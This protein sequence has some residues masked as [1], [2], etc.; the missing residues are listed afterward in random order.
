MNGRIRKC[1]NTLAYILLILF[2]IVCVF[3]PFDP[4]GLK[5]PLLLLLFVLNID[6]FCKAFYKSKWITTFLLGFLFPV[7]LCIYSYLLTFNSYV[8]LSGTYCGLLLLLNIVIF[9]DK[10]DYDL[11]FERSVIILAFFIL[12]LFLADIFGIYDINSSPIRDFIYTYE[13]GFVGKS[14]AYS[15]YYKI[16]LRTSPLIIY[17]YAK[18]LYCGKYSKAF[19]YSVALFFLE[20]V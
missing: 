19:I 20:H 8:A 17:I 18:A 3:F 7:A 2:V 10:I 14:S 5:I 6:S 4:F 12:F 9:Y 11:I 15:L 13:M 16:F 1:R